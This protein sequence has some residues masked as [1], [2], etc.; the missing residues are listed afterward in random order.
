MIAK[1]FLF[2]TLIVISFK[3]YSQDFS[4]KPFALC[5]EWI[6]NDLSLNQIKEVIPKDYKLALEETDKLVYEKDINS[7]TYEIKVFLT[8]KKIVGI[9][10]TQ[11]IDR[12]WK[13]MDELEDDL[14]FKNIKNFKNNGIEIIAYENEEKNINANLIIDEN[15]RIISCFY[16]KK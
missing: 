5:K 10:F 12:V 15:K 4:T 16:N 6:T 8:N 7:K 11:H 13:I 9:M 1:Y 14:K 3:V 2:T